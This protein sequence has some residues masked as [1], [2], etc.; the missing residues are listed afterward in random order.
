MWLLHHISIL[1]GIN[2]EGLPV[3]ENNERVCPNHELIDDKLKR[4]CSSPVGDQTLL[5]CLIFIEPLLNKWWSSSAKISP[6][7]I[8]WEYFN[9][10]LTSQTANIH[11][12]KGALKLVGPMKNSD[13]AKNAFE[14]FVGMLVNHLTR[15]P[16]QW[17]KLKGRIYSKLPAQKTNT[18]SDMG[19]Y[20][21]FLLLT[22]VAFVEFAD[23]T[24]SLLNI[25]ESLPQER[26]NTSLIWSFYMSLVSLFYF[27]YIDIAD[28]CHGQLIHN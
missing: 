28:P 23:V 26:Q 24:R 20:Q 8:L 4:L 15:H 16:T 10:E 5:N 27:I 17:L 13:G 18:L 21:I 12:P 2:E 14:Y 7:Q 3:G 25:L 6:Y 1:H 19:L 9:K 22:S 11:I